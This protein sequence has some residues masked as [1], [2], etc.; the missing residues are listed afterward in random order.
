MTRV[1][2]V[3]HGHPAPA[4]SQEEPDPSLS[5]LGLR[6]ARGAA[7]WLK[8]SVAERPRVLSSSARRALQT[9]TLIGER[10]DVEVVTD[11]ELAEIGGAGDADPETR[12]RVSDRWRTGD[13]AARHPNGETLGHALDR[14]TSVLSRAVEAHPGD[15]LVLVSHKAFVVMGLLHLCEHDWDPMTIAELPH[16]AV[17]EL[18]IDQASSTSLGRVCL[19]ESTAAEARDHI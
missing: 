17:I 8:R 4:V 10:L 1:F 9:A 6:Q 2:Y 18:D 7:D 19:Q 13:R 3:R 11:P 16:C 15:D 14:F 5:P 12:R